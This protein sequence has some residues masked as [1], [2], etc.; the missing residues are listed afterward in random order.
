[1]RRLEA[2]YPILRKTR[3]T[4]T[5]LVNTARAELISFMA[6]SNRL[7]EVFW[8]C[9]GVAGC[10]AIDVTTVVTAYRQSFAVLRRA[11][12]QLNRFTRVLSSSEAARAAR[13]ESLVARY[14]SNGQTLLKEVPSSTFSC[15]S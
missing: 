15:S 9:E 8:Q 7:P 2:R 4:R 14:V 6:R 1:L 10:T 12:R 3:A 13:V 5:G 11:V